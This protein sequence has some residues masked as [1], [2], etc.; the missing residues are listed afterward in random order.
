MNIKKR[1]IDNALIMKRC[2]KT[3]TKRNYENR[4]IAP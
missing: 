2:K 4:K 3:Q 1:Q